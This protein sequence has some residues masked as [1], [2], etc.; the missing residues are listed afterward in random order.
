MTLTD[1]PRAYA[2]V[3]GKRAIY[4]SA[5]GHREHV[6][7]DGDIRLA[8]LRRATDEARRSGTPLELI[9]R[10]D[11]GDHHLLIEHDG[12]LTP[13]PTGSATPEG[14][15]NRTPEVSTSVLVERASEVPATED[16]GTDATPSRR[17]ATTTS[18]SMATGAVPSPADLAE[19]TSF[20]ATSNDTVQAHTGWRGL[21]ARL[22]IRVPPSPYELARGEWVREVSRQWAGC[23]TIA[24]VNGKGG[25]GKTMTS[26][27]LAAVYARHGGGTVLAWDNNDTRGTLG[28]RTEPGLYD[29]TIRDL[30]PAAQGLLTPTA[31][32][33]DISR[34]VHHQTADRYDVLR[35]NPEL[36]A[37]DQR[38]T[39]PQFDLLM[40]VAA[41]YYR[42][43]VFDSGNDE[44]ADRW[45]RMIDTTTQLVIPS[46]PTPESAEVAA[47]LLEALRRRDEASARLAENAVVVI[48]Q[49][50]PGG[51]AR[52]RT[53]AD[54]FAGWVRAVHTIPFDPELKSGPLRLDHVRPATRDAWLRVAAS[55]ARGL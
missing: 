23:R 12:T 48:T 11:R 15:D 50:E 49:P 31:S 36:L 10:G 18:T 35:S 42:L 1:Y 16:G 30:L 33:S 55:A 40:Q 25:V 8:V 22:G 17:R 44:S 21:L 29:T 9:T 41:R 14:R 4:T 39:A 24:V 6:A 27:M 7:D 13:L 43:V 54:G 34:Y 51:T 47:L 26:A 2:T 20:I 52:A 19:R 5:D 46:L 45:I 3:T 38:V 28:W 53:I 37:A 32:M